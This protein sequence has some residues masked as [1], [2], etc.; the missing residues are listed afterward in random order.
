MQNQLTKEE[1]AMAKF[2][3]WELHL[4]IDAVNQHSSFQPYSCNG[5]VPPRDL[6]KQIT[7]HAQVGD[8]LARRILTVI[9][10]SH[11]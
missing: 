3:G 10:E 6:I 4:T 11:K 7:N 9:M 8:P 2:R 5:W 1:K